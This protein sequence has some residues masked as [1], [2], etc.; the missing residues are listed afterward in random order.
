MFAF[1]RSQRACP[2]AAEIREELRSLRAD[3]EDALLRYNSLYQ[4]V[5]RMSSKIAKQ[6]D[7]ANGGDQTPCDE[8]ARYRALL[9]SRKLRRR[10]REL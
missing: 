9:L 6:T 4:S 2:E 8:V 1:L 7:E 10:E 5:R 3:M